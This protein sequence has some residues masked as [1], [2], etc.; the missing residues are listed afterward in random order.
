MHST[1]NVNENSQPINSSDHLNKPNGNS[2][3]N[4]EHDKTQPIEKT[5][6]AAPEYNSQQTNPENSSQSVQDLDPRQNYKSTQNNASLPNLSN[7]TLSGFGNPSTVSYGNIPMDHP[8]AN[9]TLFGRNTVY[10]GILNS[11]AQIQFGGSYLSPVSV[12]QQ[13]Q[14][15]PMSSNFNAILEQTRKILAEIRGV[16]HSPP[17]IHSQASFSSLNQFGFDQ[18]S[19]NLKASGISIQSQPAPSIS[20]NTYT[21][22]DQTQ[23]ER[24][25]RALARIKGQQNLYA[26]GIH[27]LNAGSDP[28]RS[29]NVHFRTLQNLDDSSFYQQTRPEQNLASSYIDP[30]SS[31]NN[32][33]LKH[34]FEANRAN[35]SKLIENIK[36]KNEQP[37]VRKANLPAYQCNPLSLSQYQAGSS[38][39][40]PN[41]HPPTTGG[42]V[43]YYSRGLEITKRIIHERQ[44][45]SID[46]KPEGATVTMKP[47]E[48]KVP[49]KP[50]TTNEVKSTE[51]KKHKEGP[52]YQ[53][54]GITVAEPVQREN[55]KLVESQ[56]AQN[57]A[58]REE[59]IV[60][61]T[62]KPEVAAETEKPQE[63]IKVKRHQEVEK[64]SG[65][66]DDAEPKK[67][68]QKA[69]KAE[70]IVDLFPKE[71]PQKREVNIQL[72]VSS[73]QRS[74]S[75]KK[76]DDAS[77]GKRNKSP[78]NISPE[79]QNGLE[80]Q[81]EGVSHEKEIH[82][83]EISSRRL[84]SELNTDQVI[85]SARNLHESQQDQLSGYNLTDSSNKKPD[86]FESVHFS[87]IE[88]SAKK[89]ENNEEKHVKNIYGLLENEP[90]ELDLL[91]I[92]GKDETEIFTEIERNLSKVIDE[93]PKKD[94][95]T[96]REEGFEKPETP[97]S[98]GSKNDIVTLVDY[99][100]EEGFRTKVNPQEVGFDLTIGVTRGQTA[101]KTGKPVIVNP[102]VTLD[103]SGAGNV[104]SGGGNVEVNKPV[105]SGKKV[106]IASPTAEYVNPF[107]AHVE[108]PSGP[109]PKQKV[110]KSGGE[111]QQISGNKGG[112]AKVETA[113]PNNPFAVAKKPASTTQKQP[114]KNVAGPTIETQEKAAGLRE[115]AEFAKILTQTPKTEES[116]KT[117][118]V[119]AKPT[120]VNKAKVS[121]QTKP[122]SKPEPISTSGV[123]V[124]VSQGSGLTPHQQIQ[125]LQKNA[126]GGGKT[127]LI[128]VPST[129]TTSSSKTTIGKGSKLSPQH[130]EAK[131][132]FWKGVYQNFDAAMSKKK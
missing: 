37:D 12:R 132:P 13:S 84:T 124:D 67:S 114:T 109:G 89:E 113:Q 108:K 44:A 102:Q 69:I 68:P 52:L 16:K 70:L 14:T 93:T 76:L 64:R 42:S 121:S 62:S 21:T 110:A 19:Q 24:V 15:N 120:T 128:D 48:G 60:G 131:N 1:G 73:T 45:Q 77:F 125:Q 11:N 5:L 107:G 85:D 63:V 55:P 4:F 123:S 80:E 104:M 17:E 119:S 33:L 98:K 115:T 106:K 59:K 53:S 129:T 35:I 117:I 99:A 130:H 28:L 10:E 40:L 126:L 57:D 79:K 31:Q 23:A 38:Y 18:P 94:N 105:D 2:H 95:I 47:E 71:S 122:V 50:E 86:E 112:V 74:S 65:R 72:E 87:S 34:S 92:E 46:L 29:S 91:N 116:K 97:L 81:V 127:M 30:S 51:P 43:D 118:E 26:S 27:S 36:V 20:I 56:E 58:T 90:V 101:K 66:P 83:E 111:Q 103:I 41:Y 75:G 22:L 8:T 88:S 25:Q 78:E 39:L 3:T 96:I 32:L 7:P 9:P 54:I 6:L 49:L 61:E 100:Q 82:N